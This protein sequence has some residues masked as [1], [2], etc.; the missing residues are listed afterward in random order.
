ML[1]KSLSVG[2]EIAFLINNIDQKDKIL[3]LDRVK[4]SAETENNGT[5][6]SPSAHHKLFVTYFFL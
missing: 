5:N 2:E 3:M 1:D 6:I 4:S